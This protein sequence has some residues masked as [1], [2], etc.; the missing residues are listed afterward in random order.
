MATA[1]RR[2]RDVIIMFPPSF[3]E[4]TTD[5]ARDKGPAWRFCGF[6]GRPPNFRTHEDPRFF[7]PLE[8][9]TFHTALHPLR[10][11]R[12]RD[13]WI[14]GIQEGNYFLPAYCF[15][16]ESD[17]KKKKPRRGLFLQNNL[18]ANAVGRGRLTNS[19]RNF[20]RKQT[21]PW[22]RYRWKVAIHEKS[23][24]FTDS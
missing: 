21:I 17:R 5:V 10:R 12:P 19:W 22:R 7:P 11:K 15:N 2:S 14:C 9:A 8:D 20:T 13:N 18:E 23:R 6:A 4:Q 1:A 16:F 24:E 3:V